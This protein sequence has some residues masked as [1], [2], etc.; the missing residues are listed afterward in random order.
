MSNEKIK[1]IAKDYLDYKSI[2]YDPD[3]NHIFVISKKNIRHPLTYLDVK[4]IILTLNEGLSSEEAE[5]VKKE[6]AE[7]IIEAIEE[8]K[9]REEKN[10]NKNA[11]SKDEK[12]S[13]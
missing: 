7:Y 13:K 1:K 8:K 4:R 2:S 9:N 5:E 6:I 12:T 11:K 3:F 10:K